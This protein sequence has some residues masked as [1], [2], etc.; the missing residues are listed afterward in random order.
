M[1]F[2]GFHLTH[3]TAR[4]FVEHSDARCG[5]SKPTK[6]C[7]DSSVAVVFHQCDD[8]I[9]EPAQLIGLAAVAAAVAGDLLSPPLAI[10][11]RFDIAAWTAVPKAAVDEDGD[12][13]VGEHEVRPSGQSFRLRGVSDANLPNNLPN[14]SLRLSPFRSDETHPLRH[15]RS[16]LER[17]RRACH[18][19][20]VYLEV[21]TSS[22]LRRGREAHSSRSAR[23]LQRNELFNNLA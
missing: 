15:I 1:L 9:A 20:K 7:L 21:T 19:P 10:A 23:E 13:V 11:L 6:P 16:W 8:R 2:A 5:L 22:L 4:V 14:S 18:S 3:R 12:V 17:P